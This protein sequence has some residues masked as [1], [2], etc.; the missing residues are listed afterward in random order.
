MNC[1]RDKNGTNFTWSLGAFRYST[2]EVKMA[3]VN[4]LII[5]NFYDH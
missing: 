2:V 4:E 5:P 3:R 1:K